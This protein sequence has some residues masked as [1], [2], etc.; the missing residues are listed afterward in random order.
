MAWP[1]C[2]AGV[3][4]RI[5]LIEKMP[6][7]LPKAESIGIVQ[8]RLRIDVVINRPMPVPRMPL[9]RLMQALHQR[10]GRQRRLLLG[11]RLGKHVVRYKRSTFRHVLQVF[12]S[13]SDGSRIA[14]PPWANASP[15]ATQFREANC[16]R[17]RKAAR[18]AWAGVLVALAVCRTLVPVSLQWRPP[19][20]EAIS[21]CRSSCRRIGAS[22]TCC[23]RTCGSGFPRTIW[24]TS[25]WRRWSGFRCR[26]SG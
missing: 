11:E 20:G 3:L 18:T 7:P 25:C 23:R 19:F 12:P 15:K 10:V 1:Q 9:P 17:A 2:W 26:G 22:R 4:R 6:A 14:L 24:C 13:A 5:C 8:H 16:R 21:R